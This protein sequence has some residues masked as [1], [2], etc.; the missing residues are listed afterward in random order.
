MKAKKE[1]TSEGTVKAIIPKNKKAAY[2]GITP[3]MYE[4]SKEIEEEFEPLISKMNQYHYGKA[5][6]GEVT[7]N[8]TLTSIYTPTTLDSSSINKLITKA[9]ERM[10]QIEIEKEQTQ[11]EPKIEQ[12]GGEQEKK[13]VNE[14]LTEYFTL[15]LQIRAL[16]E[17][18]HAVKITMKDKDYYSFTAFQ[19]QIG[20]SVEQVHCD[21]GSRIIDFGFFPYFET[22]EQATA[23]L[24]LCNNLLSRYC[25]LH[26]HLN[27]VQISESP[28][29]VIHS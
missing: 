22:R 11:S 25:Q 9:I 24:E 2:G 15:Q 26:I 29:K 3:N 18:F 8:T 28:I 21:K 10:N 6:E 14:L 23:F 5:D 16:A 17:I 27:P 12:K 20:L 4:S 7:A 19:G 1:K 13:E